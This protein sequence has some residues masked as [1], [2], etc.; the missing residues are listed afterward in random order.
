MDVLNEFLKTKGLYTLVMI[1]FFL[2]VYGMVLSKNYMKKLMA[3]NVMQV[4]VIYFYLC[5][6]QKDGAMI[7]IQN[8]ITTDPSMYIN[9]LPHGLMLTAIVVSLGTTGV[10]IAL[11][12]RIKEIYG[13]VEE[14][15]VLRRASK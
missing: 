5:F 3:M 9:P 7:P 11:L 12:M 4:A 14:V 2:G 10:A 15:E 13:S 8:G 1:L 6:A